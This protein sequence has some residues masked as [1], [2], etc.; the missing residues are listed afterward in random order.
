MGSAACA[1]TAA[2]SRSARTRSRL[3]RMV[4]PL[5]GTLELHLRHLLATW[6]RLEE[7]LLLEA[8]N[9]CHDA[10][11]E[12]AE[13]RVVV[14]HGLVE[15][16]ALDGDAV[17]RA[18]ELALESQEVLVALE[19]G[20]PLHR[21]EQPREGSAQPMAPIRIRTTTPTTISAVFMTR[22]YLPVC[23]YKSFPEYD[24]LKDLLQ[25]GKSGT[26]FFSKA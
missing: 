17:L 6:R 8:A 5:A 24:W 23:R 22:V 19:L 25:S 18:L 21:H 15:A 10:P 14:L 13:P 26:M 1:T 11:R 3:R 16:H 20:I 4:P 12:E 7:S 2:Q 9:A